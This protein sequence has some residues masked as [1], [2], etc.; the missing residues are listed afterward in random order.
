M[1]EK[2]NSI[3]SLDTLYF[4][5]VAHL[6]M[7]FANYNNGFGDISLYTLVS[8]YIACVVKKTDDVNKQCR[9]LRA[10]A[11]NEDEV[12]INL[13][14]G[15]GYDSS[16]L[17][18]ILTGKR[19]FYLKIAYEDIDI[20]GFLERYEIVSNSPRPW[21]NDED[22]PIIMLSLFDIIKKDNYILNNAAALK[23]FKR[24][25]YKESGEYSFP[26]FMIGILLYTVFNKTN[27]EDECMYVESICATLDMDVKGIERYLKTGNHV[28]TH[29]QKIRDNY[30]PEYY[31]WDS[32]KQVF[33]IENEAVFLVGSSDKVNKENIR[34]VCCKNIKNFED[35]SGEIINISEEISAN[36]TGNTLEGV[37]LTQNKMDCNSK[38]QKNDFDNKSKSEDRLKQVYLNSKTESRKKCCFCVNYSPLDTYDS[39]MG[40]CPHKKYAVCM[41][42]K[43]CKYFKQD[44]NKIIALYLDKKGLK[45]KNSKTTII[46]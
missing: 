23:R 27:T 15:N 33:K 42:G 43:I 38:N 34:A 6:L 4:G 2:K 17:S 1:E 28:V 35:N 37:E 41:D 3:K 14:V 22:K 46:R 39:K 31:K 19:R 25:I 8:R 30:P 16:A 26:E 36:Q 11:N 18:N 44:I 13:G 29:I 5:V 45:K 21:F 20:G 10:N 24:F 9:L 12:I 40:Q 32:V 7:Y